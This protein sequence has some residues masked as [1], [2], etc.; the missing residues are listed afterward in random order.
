MFVGNF[1]AGRYFGN[2]GTDEILGRVF[3]VFNWF[4]SMDPTRV[5]SS[6]QDIL[7]YVSSR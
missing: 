6:Q 5:S 1:L 4:L 3:R 7:D 2:R